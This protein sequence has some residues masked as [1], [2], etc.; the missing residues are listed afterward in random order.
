M[1]CHDCDLILNVMLTIVADK[2]KL[3]S[4]LNSEA[5]QNHRPSCIFGKIRND[6]N[7]KYGLI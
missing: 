7:K 3:Q 1:E 2:L 5:D 6:A 4:E